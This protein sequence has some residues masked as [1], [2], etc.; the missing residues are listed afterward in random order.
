MNVRALHMHIGT[1]IRRTRVH[2][3]AIAFACSLLRELRDVAGIQIDTLDLGGGFGVPTVRTFTVPELGFYRLFGVPPRAPAAADCPSVE[4]FAGAITDTLKQHCACVADLA[5][6]TLV[7]E[8]GRALTSSAQM[9][10]VRVRDIKRG[11]RASVAVVDGG[12]QNLAFPLSYEYHACLV[13]SRANG[14][15]RLRRYFVAG[16]L[17]SPEDLLYR[18]WALPE[19]MEGDV[20]APIMDAGAYFTYSRTTSRTRAPRS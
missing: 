8:P 13:A 1:G 12:M 3:R 7:L 9:L 6:P 16:P 4:R 17:C 2:E 19:L 15:S 10:L 18:N 11:R 5:T 20:L 14:G